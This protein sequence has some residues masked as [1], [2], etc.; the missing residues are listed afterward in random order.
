MSV[1]WLFNIPPTCKVYLR[2]TSAMT[3]F[4]AAILKQKLLTTLSHPVTVYWHWADQSQHWPCTALQHGCFSHWH[5]STGESRNWSPKSS[6]LKARH[7]T[8]RMFKSLA[9][10][11]RQKQ[12]LIPKSPLKPGVSPL[13]CLSHSAW[14]DRW[15]Q[16]LIPKSPLKPGVSPLG[17]LSH[18]HDST[19]E[20]KDWSPKSSSQRPCVS[21]LGCVT[22][23]TQ[24]VKAR[25]DPQVFFSQARCLT[26]RVFK[27]LAWL[28][29]W[30]Q[31]LIP[32]SRLKPGVS[33][34]GC[35]SHW[36]DLTG[37]SKDWHLSLLSSQV[38]H[39]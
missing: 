34:L 21:P 1:S 14:L 18:W 6:S 39:H 9:W 23:M 15:K 37:E 22:G 38:S 36:H 32:K 16:G 3:T 35:L 26:I 29:R 13:G 25:T 19:G 7:L 30:K 8:T 20:S 12:G 4:Y 11:D 33:P 17:C 28:D 5:D 24:Q 10:L 2:G 31:G 27:S